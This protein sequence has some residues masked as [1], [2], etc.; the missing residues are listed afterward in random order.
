LQ[1]ENLLWGFQIAWYMIVFF[2]ALSFFYFQRAM[3]YKKN[4]S[5]M[6]SVIFAIIASFS[7]AHGLLV[8]P[9]I[10]FVL[11]LVFV[12]QK[13]F[14]LKPMI[15][16]A[17]SFIIIFTVYMHG[18]RKPIGHPDYF[19][20]NIIVLILN[21]FIAI[22]SGLLPQRYSTAVSVSLIFGITI[23]I[24][25]VLLFCY[26]LKTKRLSNNIF[27]A[28]LIIFGYLFLAAITMGRSSRN[29]NLPA[30]RY[31]TNILIIFYGIILIIYSEFRNLK[32]I[33]PVTFLRYGLSTVFVLFL[34]INCDWNVLNGHYEHRKRLQEILL[35]Y[36]N[37]P[38]DR[39]NL[40]YPWG[41]ENS[42][43]TRYEVVERNN[44]S[45]FHKP[46]QW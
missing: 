17:V 9:S 12:E 28:C 8:L 34:L 31:Y 41:D 44:W 30:D 45:V 37:Q 46:N 24:L 11:L 26:L 3:L 2:G 38:L 27:P 15:I 10:F 5:F 40:I 14:N 7:S 23:V 4:H 36:K 18:Y 16:F 22:G 43:R 19:D 29:L 21:F 32:K 20:S 13:K 42:L 6:F 25:T 1:A 33:I 39:L 35:D